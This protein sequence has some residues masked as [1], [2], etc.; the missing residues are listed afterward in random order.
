MD[1]QTQTTVT[2]LLVLLIALVQ[3]LLHRAS[4]SDQVKDLETRLAEAEQRLEDILLRL[5]H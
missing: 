5:E 1:T 2:A 3:F 4:Q